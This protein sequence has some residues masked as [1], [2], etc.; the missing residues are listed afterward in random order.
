MYWKIPCLGK[1]YGKMVLEFFTKLQNLRKE[2]KNNVGKDLCFGSN[3]LV[4]T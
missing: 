2:Q 3:T 1:D 4:V